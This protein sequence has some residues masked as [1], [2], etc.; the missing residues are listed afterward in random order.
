MTIQ[1]ELKVKTLVMNATTHQYLEDVSDEA[2]VIFQYI[3]YTI[4]NSFI[5][6]LG[7]VT[8]IINIACFIK[9]GFADS[10]NVSLFGESK[11]V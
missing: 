11:Y 9:Q 2:V 5:D 7:V 8:N 10:V 6:I 1:S 3:C 4:V